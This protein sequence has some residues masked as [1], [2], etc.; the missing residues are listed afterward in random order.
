[1]RCAIADAH[2]SRHVTHRNDSA[3]W[4]SRG[5]VGI[6]SDDG[7][8]VDRLENA[9]HIRPLDNSHGSGL[10]IDRHGNTTNV[11]DLDT[12]RAKCSKLVAE[13]MTPEPRVSDGSGAPDE[14][15][16]AYFWRNGTDSLVAMTSFP[17]IVTESA[18]SASGGGDRYASPI[19]C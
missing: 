7:R 10:E 12:G 19:P 4:W 15:G 16:E 11:W 9:Q 1:M 17:R 14:L 3:R 8:S 18:A 13:T 5:E 6:P 2:G